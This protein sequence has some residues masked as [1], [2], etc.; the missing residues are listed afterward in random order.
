MVLYPDGIYVRDDNITFF[1]G[2]K[3]PIEQG[4]LV[5]HDELFRGKILDTI[6]RHQRMS[7]VFNGN[8]STLFFKDDVGSYATIISDLKPIGTD[9]LFDGC[10][11][12]GKSWFQRS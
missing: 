5:Q 4:Y 2:V 10:N 1:C 6:K 7:F 11:S 9:E 8:R 12:P 3:L